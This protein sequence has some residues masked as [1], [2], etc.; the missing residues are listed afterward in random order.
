MEL[1]FD[2]GEDATTVTSRLELRRNPAAGEADAPLRLDGEDLRLVR[3]V[4]DGETLG[5]NRYRIEGGQLVIPDMPDAA[6]LEVETVIA[7]RDNTLLSGLY[8]SGGS[9]FTQCEAEGFRRITYFPDRPD[10][11]A[12]FTTTIRADAARVPGAAVE[13]QPGRARAPCPTGG[14]GRAGR[15]R[16]RS[17]LTCSRWSRA[18]SSRCATISRPARAGTSISRSGCGAATRTNAPTRCGPSRRR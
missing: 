10:V 2:L 4:L 9:F 7:P 6:T 17:P 14:T 11:M 5:T 13:R 1:G 8:V 15:T 16:T 18:T 12:R 3:L